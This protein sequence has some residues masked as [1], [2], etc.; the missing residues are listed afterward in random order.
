LF[1]LFEDL[2]SFAFSLL[3]NCWHGFGLLFLNDGKLQVCN[4]KFRFNAAF[5]E[6]F[7]AGGLFFELFDLEG[8]GVFVQWEF[9]SVIYFLGLE[10]GIGGIGANLETVLSDFDGVGIALHDFQRSAVLLW[11]HYKLATL[12]LNI[13]TLFARFI[14]NYHLQKFNI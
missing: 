4:L 13:L 2:F 7:I 8:E 9:E 6:D 1:V 14:M 11:G 5:F 10:E 12:N 3:L